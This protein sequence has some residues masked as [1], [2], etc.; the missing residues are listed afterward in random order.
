MIFLSDSPTNYYPP[1]LPESPF[2]LRQNVRGT[3]HFSIIPG[4]AHREQS[5]YLWPHDH[6]GRR[7][8]SPSSR[9]NSNKNRPLCFSCR[10]QPFA[11]TIGTMLT[12]KDVLNQLKWSGVRKLSAFKQCCRQYENYMAA[13]YDFEIVKSPRAKMNSYRSFGSIYARGERNSL[14]YVK[15]KLM[16]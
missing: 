5:A 6:G 4:P 14:R 15:V 2:S 16:A 13:F 8:F 1:F 12:R 9:V 7:V 3:D 10:W 11:L